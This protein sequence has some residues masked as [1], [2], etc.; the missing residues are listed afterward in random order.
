VLNA[1]RDAKLKASDIHEVVLVGGSTRVPKVQRLVKDLFGKDPHQGVNPDEVVS[2]G[3]AIQGASL[4]ETSRTLFCLTSRRCR[5]GLKP[6][7][8]S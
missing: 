3:A 7:A 5:L 1:L 8:V 2:L 6:K 4:P